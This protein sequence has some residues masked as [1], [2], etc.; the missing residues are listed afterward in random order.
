MTNTALAS[1]I[2][3]ISGAITVLSF[4]PQAW[5]AWRTRQTRDLSAGTY[6]LLV[7]QAV[8]WTIYGVLLGQAPIIWTN[9]LVLVVTM[10]ILAAKVRH[11]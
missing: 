9:S 4:M 7:A 6:T 2:G 8:G 10:I 1:T 3:S 5:R 11:G